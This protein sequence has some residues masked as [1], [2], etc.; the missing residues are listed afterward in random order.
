[1]TRIRMIGLSLVAAF[2]FAAVAA[3]VASA[4]FTHATW[5]ECAKVS[6]AKDEKGCTKEGGKGGYELKPGIGKGKAFKGKGGEGILHNV[7]PGKGDIKVICASSKD[8]GTPV[9]GGVVKVT[10]TFSKC[11]SEGAPCSSGAKKETITTPAL[12]G[13]LGYISVPGKVVGTQLANEAKPGTGYTAEFECTGLAKVRVSGAVIGVQTGDIN[14]FSKESTTTYA[15][16]P[17]LG[18]VAPG[19]TPLVNIPEFEGGTAGILLTELNGE[20]TGNVWEPEG[21]LPSGQESSDTN[22]GEDLLVK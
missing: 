21:G 1:M 8:A 13:E 3:S 6:G 16:G 22:K 9:P 4:E 17:Y 18:E 12:A 19:Y 2:A 15:V 20:E 11:K 7:I 14:A 10:A 5:Y